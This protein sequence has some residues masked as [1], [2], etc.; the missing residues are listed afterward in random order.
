VRPREPKW[1]LAVGSFW[2][3][4]DGRLVKS[5]YRLA[6]PLDIWQMVEGE[7]GSTDDDVPALVKGFIS[8]MKAQITRIAIEDSLMP[9]RFWLPSMRSMTGDAQVMFARVPMRIDQRFE[10]RS[11]NSPD[12]LAPMDTSKVP[13]VATQEEAKARRDSIRL[14]DSLRTAFLKSLPEDKR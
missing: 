12:L 3:D 9:G 11:V 6:V 13:R 8:P 1:N 4:D 7:A 5:A 2:F 10:Y 14:D